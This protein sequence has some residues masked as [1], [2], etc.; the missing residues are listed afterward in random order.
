MAPLLYPIGT[1]TGGVLYP[2]TRTQFATVPS[3]G[4][5]P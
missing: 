2:A 5:T 4:T 1:T 3:R